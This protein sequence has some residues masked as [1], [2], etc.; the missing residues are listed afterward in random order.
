MATRPKAVIESR[1][2]EKFSPITIAK[3]VLTDDGQN[4]HDILSD[5]KED[6]MTPT[7]ENSSSMSKVGQG[8]NVDFS[9][10]V[11]NGAYESMTLKG[12]TMVNCIQE[13]S[14]QDVVLP[15]EF[16][17]GQYVTINDTKESSALGVELKGQTLVNLLAY[18]I[19]SKSSNSTFVKDG[20]TIVCE[21]TV[22]AGWSQVNLGFTQQLKPLTKYLIKWD[23]VTWSNENFNPSTSFISLREMNTNTSCSSWTNG[24]NYMIGTT[25]EDTSN[26]ALRVHATVSDSL[27][28]TVTVKGLKVLEYQQG[29]E[30]WDIPY[31]EG[32]QSVKMPTL[33]TTGKNL[34]KYRS[35][36]VNNGLTFTHTNDGV[37]VNGTASTLVDYYVTTKGGSVNVETLDVLNSLQVGTGIFLS[38]NLGKNNY[39]SYKLNGETKYANN[40]TIQNGMEIVGVFVR[41]QQGDICNNLNLTIQLEVGNEATSYEPHKS[42][43]LSLPEEVVLRGIG[44][45]KD[46]LNLTTGKYVQRIGSITANELEASDYYKSDLE[47]ENTIQFG[48]LTRGREKLRAKT[49]AKSVCN[50]IPIMFGNDDVFHARVDGGTP[51][52]SFTIWMDKTKLETKDVFGLIKWLRDNNAV[53][54]YELATPI[55][56]KI[57]LPSTLKSWNTTTHIYSEIPENTLY[58]I[59]SHSNPSYPVILKPSTK[60]S[61][62]ANSYSNGHTNSAINFNLGGATASTTVGSRVTTITTP[63]AL[64]NELLTMSGR[65]N[66]LN[67]VMVIEGDVVG[68]EPYF[69][70]MCDSKSPILTNIGKNLFN[71]NGEFVKSAYSNGIPIISHPSNQQTIEKIGD[72][73]FRVV[74]SSNS[75]NSGYGQFINVRGLDHIVLSCS[76]VFS[77][78][79]TFTEIKVLCMYQGEELL[80]T[81]NHE[82]SKN[83]I[84]RTATLSLS[85]SNKNYSTN[86]Y[87]A[88][89]DKIFVSFTGNWKSEMSGTFEFTMNDVYIRK[90]LDNSEDY[91]PYKTNILSCNGDKIELTEDMFEQGTVSGAGG[92]GSKYGT[93]KENSTVRLRSKDI[94]KVKPNTNYRLFRKNGYDGWCVAFDSNQTYLGK[95]YQTETFTTDSQTHY[96]VPVL[97]KT[98][99]STMVLSA[100]SNFKLSEVDKT[101][102]LR[103]LPN[104]VCDTLN[105]NTGEY[106]QNIGEVVLDGSDDERWAYNIAGSG[107]GKKCFNLPSELAPHRKRFGYIICDCMPTTNTLDKIGVY[108][109]EGLNILIDSDSNDVGV[110]KEILAN[111]PIT[112]QYELATPIVKQVNVE[113]YPYAYENGHVLLESGSQEQ[114]LT[115]T[116]EYSIVANRGGQI[117]SNQKMVK[118]HQ[119]QLDRLQ[120]MIL[121]NLV[122]TQYEQTLTNLKY[123]LKNVR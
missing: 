121:T 116:I 100:L 109:G 65:G 5:R 103:S 119:K 51:Y 46:T 78:S 73:A 85:T 28:N 45:V 83:Y 13:P 62:V 31:F 8:D 104:G 107:Q 87:V 97:K 20:D 48:M 81:V 47:L 69:E 113:G 3:N 67:N 60:Y 16:E 52:G 118:R 56:T 37:T 105:V 21:N 19:I 108:N 77:N 42:S 94:I 123:D 82:T 59:L 18:N 101:I 44:D 112:V 55:V 49:N 96:I 22:E 115:P 14:S 99:N 79:N 54:Q 4:L 2:G 41:F 89:Y 92:V 53:I 90:M 93:M 1:N 72:N 76:S 30:N 106:V 75:Y 43:I 38:N 61:I 34:C 32:M 120:A 27:I 68:D 80:T 64:S 11:M 40:V 10:N 95:S 84:D 35:D 12:K 58:P 24:K 91:E 98:D 86:I 9:D 39:I 111:K 71:V 88:P 26:V 33:T 110:L 29:M 23:S 57:N 70:G 63:S 114:S 102:V 6:M 25:P 122:N 50:I 36:W 74:T 7:I 117:R 15:Y 17:E 66:K